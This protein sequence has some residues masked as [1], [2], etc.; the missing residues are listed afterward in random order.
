MET[1][2]F[3][4]FKENV[5]DNEGIVLLG[6]GGDLNCWLN[7][8][9]K[10]LSEEGIAETSNP[11]ELFTERYFM[12]TTGGR[13]DLALVVDFSKVD[14]GKMAMWRLRFGDCSWIKDYIVNYANQHYSSVRP[15]ISS[16]GTESGD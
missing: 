16:C 7:G 4:D 3:G 14:S 1:T 2:S 10:S 9:A 11:D 15:N 8:V 5:A 12:K 13:T 6:A